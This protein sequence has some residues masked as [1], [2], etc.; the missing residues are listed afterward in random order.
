L[1][2]SSFLH[3]TNHSSEQEN[4]PLA[5]PSETGLAVRASLKGISEYR[6]PLEDRRTM[7]RL[8]FNENT[9]GYPQYFPQLEANLLTTYPE[10]DAF[11][12]QLASL[13]QITPEQLLITNGSD[14]ALFLIPFCFIEPTRD[15]AITASPTFALIPHYLQLVQSRLIEIPFTQNYQYDAEG[16]ATV[17]SQNTVKLAIFASPDNP[18]GALLPLNH[19][20]HWCKQ[21]PET[22]FVVDEAYAE[23]SGKTALPLLQHYNNLLVTRTFSKAWGLAGLRL[24]CVMGHP[25]LIA[26][27]RCVRSPYS[28][29]AM[30]VDLASQLIP[31]Y[32]TILNDAQ[33]TMD[34]KLE[35]L[36][37]VESSGYQTVSGHGNFLMLKV[38][39]LAPVFCHFFHR[40]QILL[41][42]RSSHP[43]L[44]GMVRV[45]VGSPGE[46]EQF[47][48]VLKAFKQQHVLIFDMDGTLVDTAESFDA[49]VAQ[50]VEH[51]SG[52]PVL[53]GELETLREQGGFNDDWDAT[54]E[55]LARRNVQKSYAEIATE[56]QVIYLSL[57]PQAETWLIQPEILQRLR[58]RYRLA[59]AT[60]RYQAEFDAVW[61]ERFAPYFEVVV[62]QD[63]TPH[64]GKKPLPDILNR[65]LE[66]MNA[67]EGV[68]I[69]N[70]VDDMIAA[71][72]AKLTAIGV[73][74]TMAAERLT[75]AGADVVL[76]QPD[77][78]GL[79]LSPS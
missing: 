31:H 23:F 32:A 77:L 3:T 24:G 39:W 15:V 59:V 10:Y 37:M 29:N 69:G 55:L 41:R 78:L 63:N 28:V 49:T 2:T 1:D 7:T 16:I 68:Y 45:S 51:H 35:T 52:K 36:S 25:E 53:P 34:R 66:L 50:L 47:A 76:N 19:L 46:M 26:G 61:K 9:V 17:L 58:Q 33:K 5:L 44:P 65:A 21:Y 62:C 71:K 70:S 75:V 54:V 40:H 13:W 64:L 38:G 73:S 67:S 6:P 30:A 57:A 18:V 74:T 43:A 8:D 4:K 79:L 72:S 48:N 42:D 12:A 20:E 14:E 56:G 27:L 11:V 22:L 60:G